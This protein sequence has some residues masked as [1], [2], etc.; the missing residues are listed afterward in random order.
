DVEAVRRVAAYESLLEIA[1]DRGYDRVPIILSPA[2]QLLRPA[3]PQEEI[4][5]VLRNNTGLTAPIL[6]MGQDP[7]VGFEL[8]FLNT[9][10]QVAMVRMFWLTPPR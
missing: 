3:M 10:S 8:D 1:L 9:E 6:L 4:R 2:L 5:D 7:K